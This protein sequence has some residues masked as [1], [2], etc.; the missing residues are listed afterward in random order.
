MLFR[1]LNLFCSTPGVL[2][3]ADVRTGQALADVATMGILAQ[4][5]IAQAEL[6]SSQLQTALTSRIV[7]EQAKGVLAERRSIT[8]DEAFEILRTHARNNNLRLSDLARDVA[9]RSNDV[10]SLLSA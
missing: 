1:S 7:I 8:L 3:D 10:A 4:R 6:L 2:S 5:G 9:Q